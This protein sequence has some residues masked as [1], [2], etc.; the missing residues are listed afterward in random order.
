MRSSLKRTIS[1]LGLVA[2]VFGSV[3]VYTG[4]VKPA[5]AEIVSLRAERD[6]EV[7]I[8]DEV[9]RLTEIVKDLRSQY[10]SQT[11]FKATLDERFPSREDVPAILNQ[12]QGLARLNSVALGSVSFRY[13]STDPSSDSLVRPLGTIRISMKVDGGY[14]AFKSFLADLETNVR[15]MDL[16]TLRVS[17]TERTGFYTFDLMVDTYFQTPVSF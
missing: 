10:Q 5:Y 16:A 8:R 17:S 2:L 15:I 12:L 13:G 14:E 4:L 9:R 3:A 7:R 11:A 1:L 6:A